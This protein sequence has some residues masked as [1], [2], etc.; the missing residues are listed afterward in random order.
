M[1]IIDNARNS[2]GPKGWYTLVILRYFMAAFGLS[3]KDARMLEGCPVLGGSAFSNEEVDLQ[4]RQSMRRF[5]QSG[6]NDE[7]D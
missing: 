2:L 7:V 4:L 3:L 1:E 5:V 6:E